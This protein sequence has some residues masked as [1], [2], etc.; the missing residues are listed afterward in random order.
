MV[1]HSPHTFTGLSE[2]ASCLAYSRYKENA[3]HYVSGLSIGAN[4]N[5]VVIPKEPV[6]V[7][8]TGKAQT[9]VAPMA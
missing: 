1:W 2:G 6:H 3:T 5:T 4:F 8:Y 9:F 7:D